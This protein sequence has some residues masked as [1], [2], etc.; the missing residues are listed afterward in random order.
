MENFC[1][2]ENQIVFSFEGKNYKVQLSFE[3]KLKFPIRIFLPSGRKLLFGN[4]SVKS[5]DNRIVIE[6]VAGND[7][8]GMELTGDWNFR[9]PFPEYT[10]S[11]IED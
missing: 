2:Q 3:L 5:V 8:M 6:I 7:I 1:V 11:L 4:F 9:N 10:A